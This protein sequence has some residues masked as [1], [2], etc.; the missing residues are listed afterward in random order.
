MAEAKA[1]HWTARHKPPYRLVAT[2]S[3][4]SIITTAWL[5]GTSDAESV[6]AEARALLADPRDTILSV[7]VWSVK[8]QQFVMTYRRSALVQ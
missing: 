4:S 3:M 5:P 2:R 6:D 8:E 1:Q 7:T